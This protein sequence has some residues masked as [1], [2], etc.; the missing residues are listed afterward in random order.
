MENEEKIVATKFE[1]IGE[2]YV[3]FKPNGKIVLLVKNEFFKNAFAFKEGIGEVVRKNNMYN[4][5]NEKGKEK[6]LPDRGTQRSCP[7]P[8]RHTIQR[9]S[10][11]QPKGFFW[12]KHLLFLF[13]CLFRIPINVQDYL[14]TGHGKGQL[15]ASWFQLS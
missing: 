11:P 5:V 13:I 6:K 14:D 3:K 9:Q 4:F 15:L 10:Q 8:C 2:N 12:G 1:G 7:K